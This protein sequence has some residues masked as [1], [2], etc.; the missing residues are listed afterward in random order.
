MLG[1]NLFPSANKDFSYNHTLAIENIIGLL[2]QILMPLLPICPFHPKSRCPLLLVSPISNSC[3][4]PFMH[5]SLSLSH[6]PLLSG[7]THAHHSLFHIF[8]ILTPLPLYHAYPS[9]FPLYSYDLSLQPPIPFY[10]SFGPSLTAPHHPF[11][12]F[13]ALSSSPP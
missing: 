8:P 11:Y 3:L 5:T 12:F 13:P 6:P 4:P 2:L 1:T 10:P 9:N 7:L